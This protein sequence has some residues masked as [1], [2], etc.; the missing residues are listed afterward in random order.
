MIYGSLRICSQ[1]KLNMKKTLLVTYFFPPEIGGIENYYLNLCLNLPQDKIVVFSQSN[2]EAESFDKKQ[3]YK[4]YRADFFGGLWPPRWWPLKRQLKMIIKEEGIG[5][6]IFGHFHPLAIL[7]NC[8]DLPYFI[9]VHGTDVR[10]VK[11]NFWQKII[12]QKVYKTCQK[13][14]ANSHY[15]AK[16]VK[17]IIGQGDK[18]SV[19]YPGIN[20]SVFDKLA[21]DLEDKKKQLGLE[22]NDLIMLSLGRLAKQ[23]N[24]ATIIK[25][26]PSL[27]FDFPNLKYIIAG[28]GPEKDNLAELVDNL[29][30]KNNVKFAGQLANDDYNKIIYYKMADLFVSVSSVP[31]GFGITYLEAQASGLPVVASKIG[32]SAEAVLDQQ[33]GILVDPD[34]LS[35]IKKA[36][37]ELL[38]NKNKRI[39]Y[40]QAGRKRVQEEFDWSKQIKKIKEIL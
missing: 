9:F 2:A 12:F 27:L 4:I 33:T 26:M 20:Y 40:S 25:L 19:I 28:A 31:E 39:S 10:Q 34:N 5:Q 23:K 32:G 3:K 35:E 6:I 17:K 13:I 7:G 37:V 22:K 1:K 8:F 14:I 29:N 36:L 11:N 21:D 30:L 16:E 24:F 18:I 15:I 38:S